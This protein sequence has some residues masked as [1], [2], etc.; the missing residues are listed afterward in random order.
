M[1]EPVL[2]LHVFG[3]MLLFM[4]MACELFAG[5]RLRRAET[6]DQAR[7]LL[8]VTLMIE[9]LFPISTLVLLGSGAYMATERWSITD[10]WVVVAVATLLAFA[11]LGP[12]I[13]GRR[14]KA[15]RAGLDDAPAGPLSPE[16]RRQIA[17]PVTWG[18]MHAM[19]GGAVGLLWL[20][21]N[22]PS[23]AGSV[24]VVAVLSAAGLLGGVSGARRVAASAA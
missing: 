1:Y 13:Q 19:S 5:A 2:F 6:V 3:A 8:P 20:M 10:G 17:D 11:V 4:A 24:A 9:P 21:T 22:K 18:S 15:V 14:L 12:N 7:T 23:L 16:Q